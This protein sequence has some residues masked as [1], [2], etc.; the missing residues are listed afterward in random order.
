MSFDSRSCY[1]AAFRA[2]RDWLRARSA[3]MHPSST[4]TGLI[5]SNFERCSTAA[6]CAEGAGIA[7]VLFISLG[8][9]CAKSAG[10]CSSLAK[11]RLW[12]NEVSDHLFGATCQRPCYL[13][14][15]NSPKVARSNQSRQTRFHPPT[16]A[17][18]G[19]SAARRMP[20][21]RQFRS[22]DSGDG[23]PVDKSPFPHQQ[24]AP[25]SRL[26]KR[27]RTTKPLGPESPRPALTST[28]VLS[29]SLKRIAAEREAQGSADFAQ[30][31]IAQPGHALS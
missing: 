7:G 2:G 9:S 11:L 26:R 15:F 20:R 1:W 25:K 6:S 8:Y 3:T 28:N 30:S 29:R 27:E 17:T 21:R 24:T 14:Y 18:G 31:F 19:S 4:A 22:R 5:S 13:S 12:A 23:R 10:I 16:A